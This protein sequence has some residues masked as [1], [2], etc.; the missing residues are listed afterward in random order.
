MRTVMHRLSVT[1]SAPTII[2]LDR[3]DD[4]GFFISSDEVGV[5]Y[6]SIFPMLDGGISWIGGGQGICASHVFNALS[7]SR[8]GIEYE[9]LLVPK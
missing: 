9:N 1:D 4:F 5:E 2:F 6:Q 3:S 8:A 7:L